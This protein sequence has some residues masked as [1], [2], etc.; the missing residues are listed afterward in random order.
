MNLAG[1]CRVS[2]D[3]QKEEGTI[4]LQERALEDYCKAKP[5]SVAPGGGKTPPVLFVMP[6]PFARRTRRR[7]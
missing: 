7:P 5:S 4:A 6:S 3:N 2:T 1:Y